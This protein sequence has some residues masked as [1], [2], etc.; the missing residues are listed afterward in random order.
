VGDRAR[1][2]CPRCGDPLPTASYTPITGREW[3]EAT[4]PKAG[5][6]LPEFIPEG[7]GPPAEERGGGSVRQDSL[8]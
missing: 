4:A 8:T 2:A 7:L 5:D 3:V 1:P 6:L